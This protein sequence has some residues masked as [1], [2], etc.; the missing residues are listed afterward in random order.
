[1]TCLFSRISLKKGEG[2]NVCELV[3]AQPGK[4]TCED[5]LDKRNSMLRKLKEDK[6]CRKCKGTKGKIVS[7]IQGE[8]DGGKE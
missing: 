1:M 6:L 5:C 4:D 7:A 2:S 3:V 8:N